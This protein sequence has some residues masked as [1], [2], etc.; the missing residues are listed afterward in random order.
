M[1]VFSVYTHTKLQ[2]HRFKFMFACF[3]REGQ[4]LQTQQY[5]MS[6]SQLELIR[7]NHELVEKYELAVGDELDVKPNGVSRWPVFVT[8]QHPYRNAL[9]CTIFCSKRPKFGNSISLK[10]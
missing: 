1:C 9:I 10:D 3:V 7:L 5:Q 2:K 6:S 4:L 8:L